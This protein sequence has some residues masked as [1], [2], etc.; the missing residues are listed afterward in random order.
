MIQRLYIKDFAIINEIELILKDGFTV[1][2]GET[3]S[4]KSILLEALSVSL[5]AKTDKIMVRNGT[6]RALVETEFIGNTFRRL[7]SKKGRSKAYQNDEPITISELIKAN[8]TTVDFHGQHDQQLILDVNKHV[9]Y[10]DRYCH[11][12]KDVIRLGGI[13]Q[14][15]MSF[16]SQL[17]HARKSAEERHNRIELLKFQL[18]E[19][20]SINPTIGEDF[21]LD[22]IFKKLSHLEE[23][24]KTLQVVQAQ[25]N[26]GENSVIGILEKNLRSI[27]SLSRYDEELEKISTLF[28]SSL[29]QLQEAGANITYHLADSEFDP[30]ELAEVDERLQALEL[31]KR[32]Y[33]GSLESVIE[34]RDSIQVEIKSLTRPELSE[35]E[36]LQNIA[37]KEKE[38][39]KLAIQVHKT[40]LKNSTLLSNKVEEAMKVLNMPG[41]IFEIKISQK[42]SMDGFVLLKDE[43][44]EGNMKGIDTIEFFLSANP[45]EKV[46]PLTSIASGGEISRIMLAI[47]TVFQ[48]LD[49]VQTLVFDEI[50][51]GISGKAAGRVADQLLKLSKSKQVFCIT[52]LSQI[53]R[54][55]DH[56]LHVAKFVENEKTFVTASYLNKTESSQ[57]INDLFMSAE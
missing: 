17:N 5:G 40:R 28:E 18:N 35:D 42:N 10:L 50:D 39:S 20:D 56:H 54:K 31:L 33:G 34:K 23:I 24:L 15:L 36:L 3:G 6:E 12:E 29:I 47:K 53:A 13:F 32:K 30:E 45:G 16:R 7:L 8:E 27:D 37:N 9:D 11:H 49:P 57:I 14:E 22:K 51:S 25:V 21:N 2:T 48:K 52:H 26:N 44:I 4:G 19:I 55:A 1:I 43:L 46:K 38:F 41:A